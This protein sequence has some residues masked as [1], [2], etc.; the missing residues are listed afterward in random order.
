VQIMDTKEQLRSFVKAELREHGFTESPMP[1]Y[2][3]KLSAQEIADV[4]SYLA[5]MKGR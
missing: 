5:S 4:V 1:S 3:G 2:R